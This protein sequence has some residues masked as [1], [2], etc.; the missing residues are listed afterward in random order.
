MQ[1]TIIAFGSPK[2]G[3][4]KTTTAFNIAFL[5]AQEKGFE[6]VLFVDADS[7]TGSAT[8]WNQLRAE[9]GDLPS[10]TIFQK[11]GDKDFIK[12]IM[13]ASEKYD[14]IIIDVGGDSRLELRA[15]IG[16]ADKIYIP[17]RPSY[18]DTFNFTPVDIMIAEAQATLNPDVQ[19]YLLPC[20]VS[21]NKLM[22]GDDLHG[23]EQ[24]A[25]DLDNIK[26]ARNYI[27]DRKAYRRSPK[28]NGKTIFELTPEEKR[29]EAAIQEITNLYNEIY[30]K[31]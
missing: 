14:D 26:L 9:N 31:E 27:Y 22:S 5:R 2:G 3:V 17:A 11:A 4:G 15:S 12:S 19:A 8:I 29:D 25:E 6:N 23:I 1:K 30:D 24:L 7:K 20:V 13:S 10:F 21:P 18:V 28:F 16:I